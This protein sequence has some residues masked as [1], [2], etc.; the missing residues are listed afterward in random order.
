M[1]SISRRKGFT[2]IE[3]LTVIAII[4]ILMGLLLPAMNAAK[5]AAKKSQAGT[6]M[7]SLVLAVHNYYTDY[8]IYPVNA[9][10]AS[11]GAVGYDTVYGDPNGLYSTA[12]LCNILR[13]IPDNRFN[14]KNQ[15]NLRQVVYFE[16]NNAK[17]LTTPRAGLTAQAVTGPQGN[18]IPAGAFVD[19]WGMEYVVFID[20]DYLGNVNQALG[21]FYYKNTPV[22]NA[23]VAACSLGADSQWGTAG[24]G[25]FTGSDDIATWQ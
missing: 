8:G 3:L 7:H 23:G 12:D 17:S 11:A 6:D 24:N 19:P 14:Q 4:A 10:N 18:K 21:W 15:L 5:N 1:Q 13:A 16:G 9:T 20:A 2:L 22:V 25:D